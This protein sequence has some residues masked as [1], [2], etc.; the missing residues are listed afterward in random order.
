MRILIARA[1]ERKIKNS[2]GA[3]NILSSLPGLTRQSI[4]PRD[5]QSV[6]MARARRAKK[7]LFER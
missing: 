3:K 7:P 1:G 4:R 6:R 5:G 2:F